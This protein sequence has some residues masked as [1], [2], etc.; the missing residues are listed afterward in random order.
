MNS[1]LT[2]DE[3]A[4]L[5]DVIPLLE[6]Y[7]VSEITSLRRILRKIENERRGNENWLKALKNAVDYCNEELYRELINR[8]K[9]V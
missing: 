1:L 9:E 2:Y 8:A 4:S 5:K 6:K 3:R 7:E